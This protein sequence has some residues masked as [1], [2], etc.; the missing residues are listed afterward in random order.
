MESWTNTP[1]LTIGIASYNY[2][3]YL[4][5]AFEAIMEQQ[6]CDYEI[7]YC[8]DGSTD[9]SLEIISDFINAFPQIRIRLIQG[10]N[11]GVMGN[12]N[13]IIDNAQGRYVMICDADDRMLPG[14][15]QS[16]YKIA[17]D[18]NADQIV[19]AFI[20]TDS[21]GRVLQTQRIPKNIS[22]WAWGTHHAT[23]YKTEIIKKNNLHFRNDC[24]PDDM[25]FNMIFH[26]HSKTM[27]FT[28]ELIYEWYMHDDSTSASRVK[29]NHWQ[30]LCFLKKCLPYM[31]YYDRK[32][33]SNDHWQIE[34]AAIKMYCL[35]VLYRP[36]RTFSEFLKEY[37]KMKCMMRKAFPDYLSNYYACNIWAFGIVRKPTAAII[38]YFTLFERT[39]IIEPILSIFWVVMRFK[40]IVI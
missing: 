28:N 37:G 31:V 34:Y 39:G 14:C 13:R 30:G 27:A 24:Y 21:R 4:K 10:P 17:I 15:L 6:F 11:I 7:L 38:H 35:S 8:D 18:T 3:K 9:N 26:D 12:K 29:G 16:L 5:R 36:N 40:R 33:Y 23:I 2:A 22:R 19:G 25:Y 32:H 1:F 20:Q